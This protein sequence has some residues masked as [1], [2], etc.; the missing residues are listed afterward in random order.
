MHRKAFLALALVCGM[1]TSALALPTITAGDHNLLFNTPNQKV[2][3]LIS[4]NGQ[5]PA[6]PPL[7]PGQIAGVDLVLLVG[8]GVSGPIITAI[9]LV[10][11]G[12]VFNP[13]NTGQIN[14]AAPFGPPG[15][16]TFSLTSTVSGSVS[17]NGTLAF[18]TLDTTGIAPGVYDF[19]L[20]SDNLGP[21]DVGN[22]DFLPFLINGTLTI[23]PVPEPASIVM[24]LFGAAA[25]ATVV[26][27]KHR[28]RKA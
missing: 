23:P 9:D 10:G 5:G 12:T 4:D 25:L 13:N 14:F 26:A 15:R 1:A 19:A 8:G 16:E 11:V 6:V 24:G 21:S 2:S 18:V 27:R 28:A 20:S 22:P 3:V 7:L 17:A